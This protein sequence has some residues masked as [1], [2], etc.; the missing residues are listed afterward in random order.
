M[1]IP[2]VLSQIKTLIDSSGLAG[3]EKKS[4]IRSVVK[5]NWPELPSYSTLPSPVVEEVQKATVGTGVVLIFKENGIH[6]AV[7]VKAG[8]HYQGPQYKADPDLPTYMISGGFINLTKTEGSQTVPANSSKAEDPQMGA[9]REMEEELIDDKGEPLMK[10]DPSRLKPMDTKTLTFPSG[11]RRVV[12]GMLLELTPQE[13]AIIKEHVGR[14]E[15]DETYRHAVRA[16]T[17][18]SETGKPE[19]CT[20][21]I[22]PL[23][24]I[25]EGKH[26][27]LYPDQ[28]SLFEKVEQY[29]NSAKVAR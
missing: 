27:L 3:R 22:L 20:V 14:M 8:T 19:I 28:K 24:E 12:I 21:S 11:E 6:K 10:V 17:I 26:T 2:D 29:Y 16:H 4:L 5:E 23:K 18:N 25:I 15:Q 7:V 9:V 1:D 13:V